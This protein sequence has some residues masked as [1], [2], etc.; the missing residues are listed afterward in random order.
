M[1]ILIQD[2][3]RDFCPDCGG[4]LLV[5]SELLSNGDEIQ[6]V[7]CEYHG[8]YGVFEPESDSVVTKDDYDGSNG[9]ESFTHK[10]PNGDRIELQYDSETGFYA[11]SDELAE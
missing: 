4:S 7:R 10:R 9:L 8:Y 6:L 1:G 11:G 2:M 5:S 3:A